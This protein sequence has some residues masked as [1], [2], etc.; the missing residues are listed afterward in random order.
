M[1]ALWPG[2]LLVAFHGSWN[3][4][5]KTGY[6]IVIIKLNEKGEPRIEDFITG[7]LTAGGE[8]LGRPVDIKI[9]S[10]KAIYISDDQRGVIYRVKTS[11]PTPLR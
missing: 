1:T 11:P 7:W 4:S 10:D 3:R 6:K 2:N 5:K 8:V 9:G